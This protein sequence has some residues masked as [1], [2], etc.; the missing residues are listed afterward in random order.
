MRRAGGRRHRQ[1]GAA[2]HA[3]FSGSFI[4][5]FW[6]PVRLPN[7]YAEGRL[8][9]RLHHLLQNTIKRQS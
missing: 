8:I 5:W 4:T 9:H 3:R 1:A 6:I 2:E 7:H